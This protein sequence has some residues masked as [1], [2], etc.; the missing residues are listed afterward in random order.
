ME[1]NSGLEGLI[2][3]YQW[4][5]QT[6]EHTISDMEEFNYIFNSMSPGVQV[7][8]RECLL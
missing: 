5:F 6:F 3:E 4:W 7:I 2:G 1:H 8:E